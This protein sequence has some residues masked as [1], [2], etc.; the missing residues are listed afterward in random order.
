MDGAFGARARMIRGFAILFAFQLAGEAVVRAADVP[1]PGHVCGMTL[2]VVALLV[3]IVPVD[4]VRPAAKA[5][6]DHLGLLFV[7]AGVG[8]MVHAD[9]IAEQWLPISV[10]LVASTFAV[11]AVTGWVA[12]AFER[13]RGP[14]A[15]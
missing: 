13:R 12:T 5:L 14:G 2:L 10:A 11:M 3:R 7:P 15:R 9:L 1:I 6:L 4:W 8:V